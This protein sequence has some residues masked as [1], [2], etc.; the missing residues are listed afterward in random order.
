MYDFLAGLDATAPGNNGLPGAG[1]GAGAGE[2]ACG[3][4]PNFGLGFF[5]I[6]DNIFFFDLFCLVIYF[7]DI[8]YMTKFYLY[9]NKTN[10]KTNL[11]NRFK[12]P[13]NF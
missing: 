4:D 9:I 12:K 5:D 13:I 8:K 6:F 11:K 1:V 10:L 7:V 3:V 2:G